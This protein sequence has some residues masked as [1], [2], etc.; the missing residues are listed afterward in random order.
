MREACKNRLLG[1][2]VVQLRDRVHHLANTDSKH[3]P[4]RLTACTAEHREVV[5]AIIVRDGQRAEQ[6]M[7]DHLTKLRESMFN[8]LTYG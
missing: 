1:D 7:R 5:E 3:N 4:A 6:C 2:T 8:K